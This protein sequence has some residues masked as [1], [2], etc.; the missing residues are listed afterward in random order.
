[1]PGSAVFFLGACLVPGSVFN[2]WNS[3]LCMGV[4]L[5]QWACVQL[6]CMGVC[7]VPGSVFSTWV[8]EAC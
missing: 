4:C 7:L 5:V 3:V 2:V 6:Q 8:F 1:M